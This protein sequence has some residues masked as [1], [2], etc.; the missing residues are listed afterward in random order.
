MKI[1]FF[2]EEEGI[3]SHTRL[4]STL[5][6]LL[7]IAINVFLF[8]FSYYKDKNYDTLFVS[9]VI[10]INLI[11]LIAEFYPKYLKQI[12]EFGA[13]KFSD[14][15]KAVTPLKPEDFNDNKQ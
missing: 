8:L 5:V 11:F 14:I 4:M 1:G 7:H 9:L 6:F 13:N 3:F 2:Q 12:I 15:K 10:L